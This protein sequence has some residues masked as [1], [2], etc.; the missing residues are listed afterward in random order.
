MLYQQSLHELAVRLRALVVVGCRVLP[1]L[2]AVFPP[3]SCT[4]SIGVLY[5][6]TV[7]LSP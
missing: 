5:G 7:C 6:D 3:D 4:V 2:A 1:D